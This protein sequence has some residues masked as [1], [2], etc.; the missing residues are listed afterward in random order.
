MALANIAEDFARITDTYGW[1]DWRGYTHHGLDIA[2][3]VPGVNARLYAPA[4]GTVLFSGYGIV[5]GRNGNYWGLLLRDGRTV[6]VY[7][8]T[9]SLPP[10][11]KFFKKGQYTVKMSDSG[12][13][14]TAGIHAH[15]EVWYLTKSLV[16]Q[17]QAGPWD[18]FARR[19]YRTVNTWT[20][21]PLPWL[22][23][24]GTVFKKTVDS[25][26]TWY[27]LQPEKPEPPVNKPNDVAAQILEEIKMAVEVAFN[28]STLWTRDPKT[29][30]LTT[31][32]SSRYFLILEDK[33]DALLKGETLTQDKLDE[34]KQAVLDAP[35]DEDDK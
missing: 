6:I 15:I 21:D 5:P 18:F 2:G 1:K 26:G 7:G 14:P 31:V 28:K 8:H 3:E 27:R 9:L 23:K 13:S 34:I 30:K 16:R 32:S 22:T 10:V 17:I 33:I 4:S 35:M 25:R 20:Q 11:G 24:Q 12:L 19:T 29:G